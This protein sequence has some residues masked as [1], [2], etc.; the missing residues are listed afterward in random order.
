MKQ[1]LHHPPLTY[2]HLTVG[3]RRR[4][5]NTQRV[6]CSVAIAEATDTWVEKIRKDFPVLQEQV[7]G[8]DLVYLDNAA[9]SQKPIQV[10]DS[11]VDYYRT[12][13]SNVHRGVHHLSIIAT[14]KYEE[15]REKV[16]RLINAYSSKEVVF[17]RNASEAINLVAY[18]WALQNLRPGDEI[19]CSVAEHHS[20]IVPWQI[21]AKKT[22]AKLKFLDLSPSETELDIDS[23]FSMITDNTKLISLVHVSNMMGFVTPVERILQAKAGRDDIKVLLDCCQSVPHMPVDVQKLGVDWIVASGHK[24][25]GPTGI[26]FLWGRYQLLESMQPF[27]GGGEMIKDVFLEESTYADPPARFE[28][29][30]PAIGES[31]A[32]GAACDYLMEIGMDNIH[33]HEVEL[34]TY[35]YQK[36]QQIDGVRI[37]GPDPQHS[38]RASLCAFNV[39]GLHA[40]DV[41]TLLDND[42]I[43]VRSGHHC[44]QPL[45]R[46]LG[47]NASARASLYL[48][49]NR[50]EVD[51]FIES[52]QNTIK[53]FRQ[54]Q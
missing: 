52:L 13:N 35:L 9:T 5:S 30:T 46:R 6:V 24:M 43:A 36:L 40:T 49:N 26:G 25:C 18:S 15:A 44:T 10:I 4:G 17:C 21:V 20:N 33:Q 28:A 2:Q 3:V 11:L 31:I 12:S 14:Q 32:L 8:K 29:G 42:G 50:Q 1:T 22:G 38:Q 53:F 34:G 41:S 37:Y 23:L 39:D 54:F 48:Y 47:V 45:H 16:A 7:N 27:M 51:K 19:I